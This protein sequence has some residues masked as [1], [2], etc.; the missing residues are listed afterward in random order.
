MTSKKLAC[1]QII[2]DLFIYISVTSLLFFI[3]AFV[4]PVERS[5]LCEDVPSVS[6]PRLPDTVTPGYLIGLGLAIPLI[7]MLLV[8]TYNSIFHG[9]YKFDRLRS[10]KLCVPNVSKIWSLFLY[11]ASLT[12]VI[13]ECL[14]VSVGRFRPHFITTCQPEELNCTSG[15]ILD[16][17]TCTYN[18]SDYKSLI[19]LRDARKSFPSGHASFGMYCA[20]FVILYIE[21]RVQI[22]CSVFLKSLLQCIVLMA[23][24]YCGVSRVSDNRH[25]PTDVLAG[26]VLGTLMAV[27]TVFCLS[28]H[29]R[30]QSILLPA[31]GGSPTT[32]AYKEPLPCHHD[33]EH[34]AEINKSMQ[35]Q[36]S[37]QQTQVDD[38]LL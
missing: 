18:E 22:R 11:G 32:A 3:L 35:R 27:W 24:L 7:C 9:R 19:M 16:N 23:G 15:Q 8:E 12:I 17:I 26:G 33:P 5:L 30:S 36:F 13:T 28:K 25:F 4:P 37:R 1:C 29:S 38:N 10:A 20:I 21:S 6:N 34:M 2:L 31:E 14:K